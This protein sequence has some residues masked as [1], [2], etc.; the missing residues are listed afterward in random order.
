MSSSTHT[1]VSVDLNAE[2]GATVNAT[3]LSGNTITG[4][5]TI[6]YNT[7]GNGTITVD[8]L[9]EKHCLLAVS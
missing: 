4:P 3:V 9:S 7:A 1:G 5:V 8:M 6:N 2:M